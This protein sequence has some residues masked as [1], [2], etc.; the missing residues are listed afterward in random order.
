[1]WTPRGIHWSAG[2]RLSVRYA[3]ALVLLAAAAFAQGGEAPTLSDA[4]RWQLTALTQRLELAQLR[5]QI[6]QRDF[7]AAK[8]ELI[9]VA[10]QLERDGYELD[11]S[12]IAYKPARMPQDARPAD[13]PI[14]G[15]AKP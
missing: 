6:A 13:E 15:Q 14:P 4:Q 10:K 9:A 8:S 1:M 3:L 11:L 5:A 7:D 2:R 12:T